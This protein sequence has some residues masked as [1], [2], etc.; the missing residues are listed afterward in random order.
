M[1]EQEEDD[2]EQPEPAPPC[3]TPHQQAVRNFFDDC[4]RACV[5]LD[6][7]MGKTWALVAQLLADASRPGSPGRAW[8]CCRTLGI[9]R[10]GHAVL[11]RLAWMNGIDLDEVSPRY[12][13]L[14]LDQ[15]G[16]HRC[17]VFFSSR[18]PAELEEGTEPALLYLDECTFL[19]GRALD[20][21]SRLVALG[22]ASKVR[23]VG[24]PGPAGLP[25]LLADAF[26]LDL[27]SAARS[28][29]RPR[30]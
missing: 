25:G 20:G 8:W 18:L 12:L 10:E 27:T 15:E 11:R 5:L 17:R 3:F 14:S 9:A 16:S 22:R 29:P 4:D 7:K 1:Q 2:A 19:S 13:D 26:L 30:D 28:Q 6:R 21:A 23:A 24:S